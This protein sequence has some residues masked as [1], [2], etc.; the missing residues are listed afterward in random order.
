MEQ[1]LLKLARN[2]IEKS[3]NPEILD[4]YRLALDSIQYFVAIVGGD[5]RPLYVNQ[6]I[7]KR[8]NFSPTDYQSEEKWHQKLGF[9]NGMIFEELA[10]GNNYIFY[11]CQNED[12][13]C[14]ASYILSEKGQKIGVL[15]LLTPIGEEMAKL[16][17]E[18][19]RLNNR[20]YDPLTKLFTREYFYERTRQLL[21]QHPE[22]KYVLIHWN[23]QRFKVIN[24][25]FGTKTGDRV[26]VNI[27]EQIMGLVG[28]EGTFSRMGDDNFV[29]C[30]PEKNLTE[31]WLYKN[32]TITLINDVV[33]YT[34]KSTFGIYII[35]NN[36]LP[37]N[38]MCNRVKMAQESVD[39]IS[40]V[41]GRP[42]AYY[43]AQMRNR[44]LEEQELSSQVQL[45]LHEK[46]FEAYFQP[47]YSITTGKIVSAEALVRWNHPDKGLL[48]PNV[49]IPLLE[50]SGLVYQLDCYVW[51]EVSKFLARQLKEGLPCVPISVNI[52]RVDFYST[53]LLEDLQGIVDGNQ[54]PKQ[55]FR[56]EVTESAYSDD[57]DK[58]AMIV[59][60]LRE[61][62]FEVLLDDF[63]SGYSSLNTLKD[64]P[65]DILKVDMRFLE[66]FDESKRAG[67]I[68][69]SVIRMARWLNMR[70][71]AEGVETVEQIHF[72]NG[73]GCDT[74][75]GYFFSKPVPQDAFQKLLAAGPVNMPENPFEDTAERIVETW[76]TNK[77]A[78]ALFD[79]IIGTIGFYELVNDNLELI[80]V[81]Q[82]YCQLMHGNTKLVFNNATNVLKFIQPD[83][84][85]QVLDACRDS[86]KEGKVVT[87]YVHRTAFDGET[88]FLKVRIRFL[89]A[90]GNRAA[91]YAALDL[92]DENHSGDSKTK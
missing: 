9:R 11:S 79:C 51:E 92:V 73:V 10:K 52:S 38:T 72:L 82:E 22:Q 87:T 16:G 59:N 30:L 69:A 6:N 71:V 3:S 17:L 84:Q 89:G 67:N 32:A 49:F 7:R 50:R 57:P 23:V 83:E 70:V 64:M 41:K 20:C 55:Y 35:E 42:F 76:N 37:V 45:A 46:Q 54:L 68:M 62:G 75:Q 24:D 61:M 58:L 66:N 21:D 31:E 91:F 43:D 85:Q 33:A 15:E 1:N 27:S 86:W 39:L 29:F 8:F 2:L 34:F 4:A 36:T 28:N 90:T 77:E 47:I 44:I 81:N 80:R 14:E 88:I 63:G 74:I 78:N 48:T 40:I 13:A 53:T 25:V 56:V 60:E 65:V 19:E 26:L 18:Q 5:K 12:Y